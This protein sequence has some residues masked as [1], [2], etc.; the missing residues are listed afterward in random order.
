MLETAV[1]IVVRTAVGE[2]KTSWNW[3]GAQKILSACKRDQ[4]IERGTRFRKHTTP[5][6]RRASKDPGRCIRSAVGVASC[7]S[8][9]S[10]SAPTMSPEASFPNTLTS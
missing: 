5:V 7:E 10:V 9:P 2:S 8:C 6:E 3:I 1:Q 4:R